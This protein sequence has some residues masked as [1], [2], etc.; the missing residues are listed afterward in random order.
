MSA[1]PFRATSRSVPGLLLA[2]LLLPALAAAQKPEPPVPETVPAAP[3]NYRQ[4]AR[5]PARDPA[6]AVRAFERQRFD[7][8][9]KGDTALLGRMLGDDLTYTHS[10]GAVD[11]KATFLASLTSGKL[12]YLALN[13]DGVEARVYGDAAVLSGRIDMKVVSEGKELTIPAR[14]TSVYARRHGRWELVAWQSTRL[15]QP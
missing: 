6:A 9:V 7:A 15:P 1:K 11:T 3:E 4:P 12:R 2:L 8:M 13:P 10:T 14:Y 5:E